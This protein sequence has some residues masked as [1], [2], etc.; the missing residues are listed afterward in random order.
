MT[1]KQVLRRR[2]ILFLL[3]AI[4]GVFF[5]IIYLTTGTRQVPFTLASVSAETLIFVSERLESMMFMAVATVGF[6]VSFL[7]LTLIQKDSDVQRRLIL[8]GYS[9]GELIISNLIF[10]LV[11]LLVISVYLTLV[12]LLFFQPEHMFLLILGF[13][14]A[15][16]V[17]GAYGLIIG[18]VVKGELEGI[19][20][21]VLLANIDAGWLQNPV[22]YSEAQ[23]QEIIRYLPAYY[24]SQACLISSF[25]NHAV[26]SAVEGSILYGLGFLI[27]AMIVYSH[28]M[29]MK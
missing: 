21:V 3:V 22:F 9:P 19:L 20:F 24:P 27:V 23:N 17:Y 5:T 10:L 7:S 28:K 12:M 6:L 18:S 25:T 4:P 16:F 29:R 11:I 26:S 1:A 15:G 2:I 8:C 14:L 13:V